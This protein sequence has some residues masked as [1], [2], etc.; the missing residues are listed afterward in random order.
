MEL[1]DTLHRQEPRAAAPRVALGGLVALYAATL[2]LAACLLF[3]LQPMFTKRVLPLLGGTPAVWSVATVVFQALLLAGYA[4]AHALIRWLP[5]RAGFVLHLLVLTGGLAVL[6]VAVASGFEAPPASGE[7]LWL[8]TL[9]VAS[10]GLPF[11]ALSASAPLLQAWFARSGDTRADDPYFLYRASNAGSFAAL[12]AYPLLIE[13]LLGLNAQGYLWSVGYGVLACAVLACGLGL[14]SARMSGSPAA[15]T[16]APAPPARRRLAWVALSAVPA[17]LLVAATAHISTDVAAIPLIWVVPLALYL[18]SF[19]VAFRP[20]RAWPERPLAAMQVVG[21]GFA[22]LTVAIGAAF[23]ADLAVTLALLLIN[24][25]IAHRALYTLRPQAAR[26]TEFY[27]CTSLGGVLGGVFAALVAP[28]LFSGLHEYPLLLAAALACRPGL[29]DGGRRALRAEGTRV[30]AMLAPIALL[31]GL[32]AMLVTGKPLAALVLSGLLFAYGVSWRWPLRVALLGAVAALAAILLQTLVVQD[33]E[34]H[35]SFFGVHR[36]QTSDD[37]R[38]RLLWHGTTLHG[39]MRVRD[40]DGAPTLGLPEPTTYYAPGAPLAEALE[41][42]RLAGGGIPAVSVVGLGAGSLA[43]HARPGEAWTFFEIDPV[44][45][46][47][48]SDPARFR[49][50]SDC[51]PDAGLVQGDARLTLAGSKGAARVLIL[52]AFSSDAIPIHLLTGEALDTVLAH[53]DAR[54]LLAI[55]ISNRHFELRHVL[56]R[57]AAE[58]GMRLLYREGQPGEAVEKRLRAPSQVALL[59]RDPAAEREAL[60][61]GWTVVAPNLARRPWSDDY[62]NAIEAMRDRWW[63][64]EAVP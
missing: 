27:L 52:D 10:V 37:G 49:F 43:C 61:R 35:R 8:V 20:G 32:A 25:L 39:A 30:L 5:Q 18:L 6:P 2:L 51:A 56:A 14:R 62:A 29:L 64:P 3:S 48:A 28:R 15:V 4:Y 55:H 21:T 41:I 12:I 59:T 24:A 45:V 17:A 9:F 47:L 54:G 7:A 11:F 23:L 63:P 58:R 46:R 16:Q 50:L 38:F 40:D 36:I 34:V 53:L 60:A 26:L 31:G 42:A 22:L 13:P 44:V 19:I 57:L 1:V 33:G